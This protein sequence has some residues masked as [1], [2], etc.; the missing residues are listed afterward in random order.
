MRTINLI[1]LLV[2]ALIISAITNC[3]WDVLTKGTVVTDPYDISI[4]R[5]KL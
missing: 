3:S 2:T 4:P 1:T 5:S